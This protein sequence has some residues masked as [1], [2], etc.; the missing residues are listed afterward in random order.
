MA[1]QSIQNYSTNNTS[2]VST[3]AKAAAKDTAK[4]AAASSK[5]DV[6][7]VYEKSADTAKTSSKTQNSALIAKL[8][9]ETDN[10]VSQ[11]RDIVSKMIS[12]QGSTIGTADDMWRFLAGGNFTVSEAAKAQAQADIADDGYW[13]VEQT[14][15]RILDFAK[16]LAGDDPDKADEMLNAFKKGFSQATKSWGKE[17]PDI[18]QRTYDAVVDKFNDWKNNKSDQAA[19]DV[20]EAQ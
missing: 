8:K 18:S 4:D 6:G 15:D 2:D 12:K 11:L 7:V 3:A 16:A 10:R 14:S 5:T 17:L 1:I 20:T 19:E 9:A 13:G